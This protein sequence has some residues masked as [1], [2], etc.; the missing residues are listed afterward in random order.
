[1]MQR[2]PS[3]LA[4][5]SAQ[6]S[7]V[8]PKRLPAS[9]TTR[10]Q[11]LKSCGARL[12]TCLAAWAD[13]LNTRPVCRPV[14]VAEQPLAYVWKN[15]ISRDEAKHVAELALPHLRQSLVGDGQKA[16]DVRVDL[17]AQDLDCLHQYFTCHTN[18]Q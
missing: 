17:N 6:L 15:F 9:Q 11:I 13:A 16:N 3:V 1:M 8:V 14:Q 10:E 5:P 18:I 4:S 2:K 7:L 12:R